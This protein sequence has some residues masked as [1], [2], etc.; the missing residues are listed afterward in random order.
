[1]TTTQRKYTV[2]PKIEEGGASREPRAASRGL[3]SEMR[4]PKS[5]N[6]VSPYTLD[7]IPK[8]MHA[9]KTLIHAA[10]LL[11]HLNTAAKSHSPITDRRSPFTV[12]T[13]QWQW[14]CGSSASSRYYYDIAG[15]LITSIIRNATNCYYY[16]MQNKLGKIEKITA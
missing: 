1:M 2:L 14:R 11:K 7:F 5:A 3:R 4:S 13:C 9:P 12:H 6:C 10:T 16:A 15:N 8:P